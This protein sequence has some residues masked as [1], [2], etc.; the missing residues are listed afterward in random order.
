MKNETPV[1]DPLNTSDISSV[2]P[3]A[4]EL[5]TKEHTKKLSTKAGAD[6][7]AAPYS[8]T[9]QISKLKSIAKAV[10]GA[11]FAL[12]L[13]VAG[14]G[15]TGI[16]LTGGVVAPQ[17]AQAASL[18]DLFGGSESASAHKKFLKVEDA[19]SIKPV[20]NGKN[21][22]V[23]LNI[24]P[25]H[26]LYKDKLSLKLPDGVTASEF[27][28]SHASEPIDDPTFGKVDV[29]RQPKVTATA[30]LTNASGKPI[31]QDITVNWQ[32]C[33]DA[34]LCYPPQK[35]ILAVSLPAAEQSAAKTSTASSDT[36]K[37][38]SVNSASKSA[39]GQTQAKADNAQSTK[40]APTKTSAGSTTTAAGSEANTNQT[41]GADSDNNSQAEGD[42]ADTDLISTADTDVDDNTDIDAADINGDSNGNAE[43]ATDGDAAQ[44]NELGFSGNESIQ[45]SA[46]SS[47]AAANDSSIFNSAGIINEDPFGLAEHPWL[48]LL[49]LFLAG[50]GLAFTPCVLP[51]LPIVSNIVARQHTPT[52]KRGLMLSGS[53]ALGVAVAYGILGAVIAVFGQQLGIIGW[54]QNPVILI[55]FAAVFVLLALYMLDVI[56]IPVPNSLRQKTHALSET[57]NK[58]LGS[59]F[60]SFVAGLLSALVVSP[61]VSAPLFGALLAVSTIG[62]PLLGFA[63][64]F[65]LGF[66]L[67]AP[68]MLLGIGQSNL[69][70]KAGEWMVWVKQGFA[71]LL[72][73]VALLLIERVLLSPV[74]LMLWS[75]WF[76]VIAVWAW[77]WKGR[78]QLFTKPMA[79]VLAI[80]SGLTLLGAAAGSQ[81]SWQP[82]R[83]LT[84]QQSV[85]ALNNMPGS[86]SGTAA[87][88]NAQGL[89]AL[90]GGNIASSQSAEGASDLHLVTLDDL[91]PVIENNDKV[92]IDLTAEWCIEC[93]I[94]DKTLFTNRPA[95][96][97][98]WQMVRLDVTETNEDSARIL[99]ELRLFGP[100][101]LLYFVDGKLV[102][103]QV[104]EIKRDEFEKTLA[105]L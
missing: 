33:A 79:I 37:N 27:K 80:W 65:M 92:L 102:E 85:P 23:H 52:A 4:V 30:V 6:Q 34:G 103:Q 76:M 2:E 51:M 91:I 41:A 67:S 68:L 62:N 18:G 35:E 8:T 69:M 95:A 53:Y 64:L 96:L 74:M 70:P 19:F 66:G 16:G 100:P 43:G 31:N 45:S 14:V 83:I 59:T 60:G 88:A 22:V 78:G 50:L 105:R 46:Q 10:T 39:N 17:Q 98:Q 81:D 5:D 97:Q 32:G 57:G 28:F 55:G 9:Q 90:P 84:Q 82:L 47:A 1:H 99:S 56:R 20:Q 44:F 26:Y 29:F 75:V 87:I 38:T 72:F 61:C 54:L 58:Y 86:A 73:A 12:S 24:T 48:A 93:R 40:T 71:L 7:R 21:I 42:Q 15:V 49:L 25:K 13:S 89:S 36:A 101:A 104:G 94:M 3:N 63:A 77:H 11:G